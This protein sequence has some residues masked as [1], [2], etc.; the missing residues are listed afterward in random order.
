MVFPLFD[1]SCVSFEVDG[2]CIHL[3]PK[4]VCAHKNGLEF[5]SDRSLPTFVVLE[6]SLTVPNSECP[7][8]CSAVVVASE[9][10]GTRFRVTVLFLGLPEATPPA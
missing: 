7:C 5:L 8:T 9:P 2:Q 1:S 10:A 6:L 3:A 4:D